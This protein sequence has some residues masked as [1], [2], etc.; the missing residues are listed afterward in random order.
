[1]EQVLAT[2]Y[3][4]TTYGTWLRGD[5]RG[6][7]DDG[8]T[9]PENPAL[10]NNDHNHLSETLYYFPQSSCP[11]IAK[12]IGDSLTTRFQLRVLAIHVDTWHCHFVVSATPHS[13]ERIVKCAKDAVRWHLRI[14]RRI[15]NTGYDKR[16]CFDTDSVLTRIQYVE[17]H[18]LR[19]GLPAK[20]WSFIS[21]V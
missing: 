7:V 9:L 8:V 21:P 5:R 16:F 17:Q 6:W 20:P 4:I 3:T 19:A 11:D 18:N 13:P 14:D 12:A 1:M 15:W 2:L 10:E